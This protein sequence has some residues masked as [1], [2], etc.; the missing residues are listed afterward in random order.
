MSIQMEAHGGPAQPSP[1]IAQC[2][3]DGYG[4]LQVK[5]HRG[6]TEATVRAELCLVANPIAALSLAK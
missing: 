5:C 3:N 1:T 2:L 6:E 4:W